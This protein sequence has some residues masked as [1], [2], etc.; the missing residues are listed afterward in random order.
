MSICGNSEARGDAFVEILEAIW[1]RRNL[2]QEFRSALRIFFFR[3]AS[4]PA[5]DMLN[6]I[7]CE[8]RKRRGLVAFRAPAPMFPALAAPRVLPRRFPT[9]QRRWPDSATPAAFLDPPICRILCG[10][11]LT[12]SYRPATPPQFLLPCSYSVRQGLLASL[13]EFYPPCAPRRPSAPL[14]KFSSRGPFAKFRISASRGGLSP[15]G[16]LL[17][18][19][20]LSSVRRTWRGKSG[21]EKGRGAP[22]CV[23]G[24]PRI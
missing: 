6:P 23:G 12:L 16:Y 3:N 9:R 24:V 10:F 19:L 20:I 17:F 7:R 11:A 15:L 14:R 22:P 13:L 4:A 1:G 21:G 2:A 5:D 8:V 18:A